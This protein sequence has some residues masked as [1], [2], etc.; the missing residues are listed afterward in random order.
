MSCVN[1]GT[2]SSKIFAIKKQM[3]LDFDLSHKSANACDC[4]A[5]F[6]INVPSC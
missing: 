5:K 6:Y 3:V 1:I 4:L 2:G